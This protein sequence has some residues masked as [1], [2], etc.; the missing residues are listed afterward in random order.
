MREFIIKN[1]R[2]YHYLGMGSGLIL[3]L[4]YWSNAGKY[5]E[6][7]L[8]NNIFLISFFGIIFG[9]ISFDLIMSSLRRFKE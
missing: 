2:W 5:S 6:Y 4:I 7:F 1:F 3:S 8:K 9:Y